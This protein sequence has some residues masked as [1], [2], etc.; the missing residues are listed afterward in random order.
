MLPERARSYFAFLAVIAVCLIAALAVT[1]WG[2]VVRRIFPTSHAPS[3]REIVKRP[4]LH[5]HS[6]KRRA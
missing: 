6:P 2:P 1:A 3:E 5:P 4:S